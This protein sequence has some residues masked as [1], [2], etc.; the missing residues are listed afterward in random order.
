M[1]LTEIINNLGTLGGVA[2][3]TVFLTEFL[4]N[5]FSLTGKSKVWTSWLSGI[6]LTVALVFAG[7][8]FGFG[9]F[10]E[11]TFSGVTD[12]A[13]VLIIGLFSGLTSNGI[14]SSGFLEGLLKLIRK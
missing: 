1:E 2:A 3:L 12:Y 5:W 8:L 14:F 9:A 4:V 6:L 10:A 7:R 13:I 11:F